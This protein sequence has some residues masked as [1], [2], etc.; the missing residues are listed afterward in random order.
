MKSDS[1]VHD[2]NGRTTQPN[3]DRSESVSS[4]SM[5]QLRQHRSTKRSDISALISHELT[6]MEKRIGDDDECDS[7]SDGDNKTISESKFAN[8]SEMTSM[9]APIGSARKPADN[10]DEMHST[11]DADVKCDNA[12]LRKPLHQLFAVSQP[13]DVVTRRRRNESVQIP[14]E[15][16]DLGDGQDDDDGDGMN[17]V[18]HDVSSVQ[19]SASLL[20]GVSVDCQWDWKVVF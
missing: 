12:V 14:I 18:H 2:G 9:S 20:F 17:G 3:D 15:R 13:N 10:V 1:A 7:D 4:T 11:P 8:S 5:S 6:E 16:F 19:S